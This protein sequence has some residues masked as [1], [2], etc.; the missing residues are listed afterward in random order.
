VFLFRKQ[1]N[2]TLIYD[3]RAF[4][5]RLKC[6]LGFTPSNLRLYE[7]AFI[8]RSASCIL[9]DGTRINNERLE[10]LGDAILD[11]ILSEYLFHK[12]PYANEGFLT[13]TRAKIVNREQLN[14]LALALGFEE[15]V[16]SHL[17]SPNP[18]YNLF[19]DALEALV[20]ALFIDTGYNK[21]RNFLIK[22]VLEKHLDLIRIFES[23]TDYKSLI[24][25]WG[26]KQKHQVTFECN[27]ETDPITHKLIFNISLL[28]NNV[29]TGTGTGN[30][31]KEAEQ[32]ASM[33]AL[34]NLNS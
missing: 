21:T 10:Y 17:T 33:K 13:K 16:V 7:T 26:Q 19:G 2:N 12:Y 5:T 14:Q 28:V 18:T 29:V 32:E 1:E 8:H 11:T 23:E 9:P 31:K 4:R 24:L 6:L 25:E 15:L 34:N 3:K 22:S 20:G 30:S 27:E